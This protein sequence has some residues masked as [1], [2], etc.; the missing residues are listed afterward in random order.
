MPKDYQ[1]FAVRVIAIETITPLVKCFTLQHKD[2]MPLPAF[3]AGSHIVVQ[4]QDKTGQHFSNAYSI[5]SD[6]LITDYYK[7]AVRL[8]ESSKGGSAFMHQQVT[9]G[10]ELD[11]SSPNNLFSICPAAKKHLL[12]AGGIGI[13]PFLA[14]LYELNRQNAEY[15]L[16]YAFR[17]EEQAVFQEL[18]NKMT[19][20]VY[21]YNG[22]QGQRLDLTALL[23]GLSEGT[24]V[25]VCGPQSLTDDALATAE[26]LGIDKSC[27][28]KE[29]FTASKGSDD[30]FTLVLAR[31]GCELQVEAGVSILQ[32]I[33][34]SNSAEVECLCREG[35]CGTCETNILEG[36]AEHL[37]QYLTDEE[38]ASG[39]TL[40][41]CVSRSRSER[42]VLD[43]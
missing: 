7:I 31:S 23:S 37:D 20:A 14:Q 2:G 40:M 29:Q 15:E 35:V 36:Q 21:C 28:H 27:L 32:A 1:L 43:L 33:E 30:A 42:L 10:T 11:I 6:P 26:R 4:M 22:E 18:L 39:K 24:H 25:Y 13:T 3:S 34:R 41:I 9:V 17:S 12:I 19:S 16:H 8:E 5:I 38:K